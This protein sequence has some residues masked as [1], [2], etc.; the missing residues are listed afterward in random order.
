VAPCA[1]A[2]SGAVRSAAFGSTVSDAVRDAVS[3]D[4]AAS[5]TAPETARADDSAIEEAGRTANGTI[6]AA[7][8]TSA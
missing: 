1:I 7:G 8:W 5:G 2:D 4:P 3:A 6:S